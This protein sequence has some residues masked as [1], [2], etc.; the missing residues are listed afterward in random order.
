[1]TNDGYKRLKEQIAP[2]REDISEGR[3]RPGAT[4]PA[5]AQRIYLDCLHPEQ[6][7]PIDH[8]VIGRGELLDRV[9]KILKVTP[10]LSD[11]HGKKNFHSAVDAINSKLSKTAVADFHLF[12]I[13]ARDETRF[14]VA[15]I[16][17]EVV[18]FLRRIES[19]F[20]KD[21][22]GK[23][24]RSIYHS[25]PSI[26]LRE[27]AS[28][29]VQLL[30]SK[31]DAYPSATSIADLI[32][33]AYDVGDV[34]DDEFLSAFKSHVLGSVKDELKTDFTAEEYIDREVGEQFDS[35]L[36]S[37]SCAFPVRAHA[38]YGKTW[39]VCHLVRRTPASCL[40]VVVNLRYRSGT[41]TE[42]IGTKVQEYASGI[43][44][45]S[46]CALSLGE[47]LSKLPSKWRSLLVID[48][49]DEY[50]GRKYFGGGEQI[51]LFARELEEVFELAQRRRA[52]VLIACRAHTWWAFLSGET[53]GCYMYEWTTAGVDQTRADYRSE[54]PPAEREPTISTSRTGVT[55][56]RYTKP[57]T[58]LLPRLPANEAALPLANETLEKIYALGDPLL[59]SLAFSAL[60]SHSESLNEDQILESYIR[61]R[62]RDSGT[63][64]SEAQISASFRS[65]V[66][67]LIGLDVSEQSP[68]TFTVATYFGKKLREQFECD[69]DLIQRRLTTERYERLLSTGLIEEWENERGELVAGPADVHIYE[70]MAR[71][72]IRDRIFAKLQSSQEKLLFLV[73]QHRLAQRNP[74][75]RSFQDELIT[76]LLKVMEAQDSDES[77]TE[78]DQDSSRQRL[79]A[80][81]IDELKSHFPENVFR[82]VW[83]LMDEPTWGSSFAEI[84]VQ[85]AGNAAIDRQLRESRF[86]QSVT[87]LVNWA[88]VCV[89]SSRETMISVL[90]K[91]SESESLDVRAAVAESIG[92]ASAL[93]LVDKLLAWLEP[94]D[95][96][97]KRLNAVCLYSLAQM[98]VAVDPAKLA[99]VMRCKNSGFNVDTYL[100]TG[101]KHGFLDEAYYENL[102]AMT[103]KLS[104]R[105]KAEYRK[106]GLFSD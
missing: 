9:N 6:S 46:N 60:R 82:F 78:A 3:S 19:L 79:Y 10:E 16:D 90:T 28:E 56:Q 2:L 53:L 17:P 54:V 98:R 7:K 76:Y 66:A 24:S 93:E 100:D 43:R 23:S 94:E 88:R 8:I 87:A 1:M 42:I 55:L 70:F 21:S 18:D 36:K 71:I 63:D 45:S 34:F 61:T 91:L 99:Q 32:E 59:C 95:G 97:W 80:M 4:K 102:A 12:R 50:I 37:D 47:F 27:E 84:I 41:L 15:F 20:L 89:A 64:R 75:G 57:Q 51:S 65:A 29:L 103:T 58:D 74:G 13:R 105:V 73:H 30:R 25:R 48:G 104:K 96:I 26:L 85:S 5:K 62:C 68:L 77:G 52:K 11:W 67:Y 81:A 69:A 38:G 35:F 14:V 49:I 72:L 33:S 39:E 86:P 92:R 44:Q 31:S 83:E 40:P 22:T 101:K 106:S